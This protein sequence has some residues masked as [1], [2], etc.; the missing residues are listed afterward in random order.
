MSINRAIKPPISP[1]IAV[2]A[3]TLFR[4]LVRLDRRFPPILNIIKIVNL[5]QT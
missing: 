2:D 5:T 3:P 4:S 1:N